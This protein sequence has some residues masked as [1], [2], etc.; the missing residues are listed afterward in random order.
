[1]LILLSPA[2]NLNFDPAPGAP[3]PTKPALLKDASELAAVAKKLSKAQI[4]RLMSISD[5][6]AEL[7][8]ER[9]Q[10]LRADGKSNGAK[11]A[12]L[13]FNGDVYLGLDAKTMSKDDF[14]FAQ[15][16]LRILS[17]LYGLLRP[18]DAIEPYRLEMGSKLKN[19]RGANLYEFWGDRIAQ[20]INKAAKDQKDPT[21][22]NLASNEYFSAVD[23]SV[24]KGPL[25]TPTFKEEKDGQLRQL[26]FFAKRARGLMARWMIDNRID[27]ARD[28]KKFN[29]EGYRLAETSKDGAS[30]LF[31][32]PQPPLKQPARAKKKAAA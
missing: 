18:L 23:L 12:A 2:K 7:N 28:L 21:I 3:A 11:Q 20:E 1:M 30:L 16:H 15:N 29:V 17:G 9:F 5:K 8:H 31:V 22:V 14:A 4:K 24:L 13:A 10:A 26:Q 6:L 19:P 25:V 27:N 32:R